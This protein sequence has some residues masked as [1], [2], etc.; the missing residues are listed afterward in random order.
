MEPDGLTFEKKIRKIFILI[1][2]Y[3]GNFFLTGPKVFEIYADTTNERTMKGALPMGNESEFSSTVEP[4]KKGK[5]SKGLLIIIVILLVL[6][7]GTVAGATALLLSRD[8]NSTENTEVTETLPGGQIGFEAGVITT[9]EAAQ[10]AAEAAKVASGSIALELSV[11]AFSTDGQTFSCYIANAVEN[12]YD[13][14]FILLD[15]N[16]EEIYRSG[17]VPVGS[18]LQTFQTV[19]PL[20]KGD[21]RCTLVYHQIDDDHQTE[22]GTVAAGITLTVQIED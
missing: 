7:I 10:Q 2:A 14:Y 12:R 5:K 9:A 22:L 13:V 16:D 1:K 17:L 4:E 21:H 19:E 20:S 11:T 3:A 15:E 8:D 6:L 18:V